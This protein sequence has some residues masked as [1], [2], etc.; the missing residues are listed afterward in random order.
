MAVEAVEAPAPP[1]MGPHE[2]SIPD[3]YAQVTDSKG[4]LGNNAGAQHAPATLGGGDNFD[5]TLAN[6]VLRQY[7]KPS[8]PAPVG[9]LTNSDPGHPSSTSSPYASQGYQAP[10]ARVD[11]CQYPEP[12]QSGADIFTF[13]R[14]HGCNFTYDIVVANINGLDK[15]SNSTQ[16][17]EA[18]KGNGYNAPP[19]QGLV[20]AYDPVLAPEPSPESCIDPALLGR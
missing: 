19:S 4:Q 12:P 6:N 10:A 15:P 1:T 20:S 2:I 11:G 7:L 5:Y 16:G 14:G 9:I 8:P 3:G 13:G 18:A 17:N